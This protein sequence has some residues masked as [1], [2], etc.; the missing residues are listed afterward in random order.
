MLLEL[1]NEAC[2]DYKYSSMIDSMKNVS[3]ASSASEGGN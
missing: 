3:W 1:Q 2:L